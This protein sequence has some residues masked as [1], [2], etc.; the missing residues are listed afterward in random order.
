MKNIQALQKAGFSGLRRRLHNVTR[1]KSI[2]LFPT[3]CS[4]SRGRASKILEPYEGEAEDEKQYN[5]I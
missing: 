5:G 3:V 4:K 1:E 2:Y